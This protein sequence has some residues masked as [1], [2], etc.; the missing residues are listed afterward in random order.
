VVTAAHQLAAADRDRQGRQAA[1]HAKLA[2]GL[3]PHLYT[4]HSPITPPTRCIQ[5]MLQLDFHQ[6]SC[7][8]LLSQ[9]GRRIGDCQTLVY[10]QPAPVLRGHVPGY[11]GQ[12]LPVLQSSVLEIHSC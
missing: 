8:H 12:G 2:E 10:L 7:N 3:H 1:G 11:P 6:S 5:Q 9:K 4:R